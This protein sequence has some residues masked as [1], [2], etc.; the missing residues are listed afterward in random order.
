M[1]VCSAGEIYERSP[2]E[3][4][5]ESNTENSWLRYLNDMCIQEGT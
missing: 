1:Q 4:K 2:R 5:I 3:I